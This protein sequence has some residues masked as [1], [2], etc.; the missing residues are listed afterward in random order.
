MNEVMTNP[1]WLQAFQKKQMEKF[2]LRGL[3]TRKEENWKYTQVPANVISDT[4]VANC[5]LAENRVLPTFTQ[6]LDGNKI[7]L[8][9]V[10]GVFS[11]ELSDANDLPEG[12]TLSPISQALKTHEQIIKTHFLNEVSEQRYPFATLN[13]ACADEGVFLHVARN[14]SLTTPIHLVFLNAQQAL[15]Q[16]HLRNIFIAEERAEVSI[17]EE[18]IS[19]ANESYFTNVVTEIS[20]G[21][22]SKVQFHKIQ[23]EA[24]GATHIANIFVHQKQD[25][26]VDLFTLTKGAR[27]SRDDVT[28][29]LVERGAECHLLGLYSLQHDEQHTDHHLHVDHVAEHGTSSML[30]KGI[31]DKKS[32][33]VFNGKVYVHPNA[34]HINA[35]QSNHNL[36]LSKTAEINTKP[37][38][39]IYADNVKCAHGATVGQLDAESLFYFRSRGIA[40]EDAMKLLLHAFADEVVSKIQHGEIRHYIQKRVGT[41]VEL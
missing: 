10:N 41:Y 36:L 9:F 37:E 11:A 34:Q 5:V 26:R 20:A 12:V 6:D 16:V 24:N 3:P 35:L 31:L 29:S 14:I 17:I 18:Y 38:L 13:N 28:V 30:Y 23:D 15:S 21:P 7:S 19:S 8:V 32:R 25:S 1:L 4:S 40:R 22:Q 39:E 27:L 33:A 2:L